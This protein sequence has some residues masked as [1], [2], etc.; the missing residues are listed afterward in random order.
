M[1]KQ[2]FE[3]LLGKEVTSEQYSEIEIVYNFHPTISNIEGKQQ[4]VDLF[5]LGGMRLIKDMKT[6]AEN[7]KTYEDE[8]ATLKHQLKE[9]VLHQLLYVHKHT[10]GR[11]K[12]QC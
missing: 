7:A 10:V 11:S 12:P 8:I 2:E 5:K 9:N 4:I 6:T 1:T 3:R